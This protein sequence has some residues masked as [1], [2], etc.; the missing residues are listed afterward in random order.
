MTSATPEAAHAFED[1]T[2]EVAIRLEAP[3]LAAL[4]VEAARALMELMGGGPPP[5]AT[6][7]PVEIRLHAPDRD[8]LLVDWLNELIFR[9]ETTGAL[10]GEVRVAHVDETNL[11]AAL[12][13]TPAPDLRPLVKA[14]SFHGLRI[15]RHAGGL[16]AT[17]I[18]DV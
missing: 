2:S 1:H 4:F 7:P 9:V 12:R 10:Y 16:D 13:G 3:S 17:V 5:A 18:L 6:D 15:T 11:L 8:A 14:A